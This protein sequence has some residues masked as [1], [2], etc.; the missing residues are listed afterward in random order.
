M[1]SLAQIPLLLAILACSARVA[2]NQAATPNI[3]LIIGDD[4]GVE[5]LASY[6]LVRKYGQDSGTRSDWQ[7]R[8][9]NSPIFGRNRF[10]LRLVRP[11]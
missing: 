10:A 2:S 7:Q 11:C 8:A 5:T 4:M 3:L 1:K 9:F 6:G